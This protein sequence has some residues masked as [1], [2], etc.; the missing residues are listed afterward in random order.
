MFS[1]DGIASNWLWIT[2]GIENAWRHFRQTWT[3]GLI[4]TSLKIANI[5]SLP[6]PTKLVFALRD[7]FIPREAVERLSKVKNLELEVVDRYHAWFFR[8][9]EEL[10]VEIFK[11]FNAR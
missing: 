7:E 4:A 2:D 10:A 1:F 5:K 11:F 6:I 3:E 9:E 8:H